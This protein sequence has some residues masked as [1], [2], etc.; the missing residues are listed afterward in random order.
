M[1]KTK[2][3]DDKKKKGRMSLVVQNN[4]E[5]KSTNSFFQSAIYLEKD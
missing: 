3:E 1:L 2:W 5:P 4:T